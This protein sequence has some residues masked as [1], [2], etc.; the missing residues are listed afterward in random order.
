MPSLILRLAGPVAAY[1]Y[2][3]PDLSEIFLSAI[4]PPEST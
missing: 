4:A 2:R 3:P 1:S